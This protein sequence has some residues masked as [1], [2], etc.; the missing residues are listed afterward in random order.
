MGECASWNTS[1]GGDVCKWNVG[2]LNVNLS[3]KFVKAMKIE[4]SKYSSILEFA[5]NSS[6]MFLI[7][8]EIVGKGDF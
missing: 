1:G 6:E 7:F 3:R 5:A 4:R 8:S 2:K